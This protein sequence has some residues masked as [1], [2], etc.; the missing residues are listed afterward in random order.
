MSCFFLC[1]MRI[2][3][4][5]NKRP[6]PASIARFSCKIRFRTCLLLKSE[7]SY[8]NRRKY[9]IIQFT[10]LLPLSQWRC[11]KFKSSDVRH[12]VDGPVLHDVSK[13]RSTTCQPVLSFFLLVTAVAVYSCFSLRTICATLQ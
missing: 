1:T 8:T 10:I 3:H 12:R 9:T 7:T 13:D 11:S 6:Q 2:H 4:F 5:N